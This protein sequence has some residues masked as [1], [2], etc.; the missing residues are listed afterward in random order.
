MSLTDYRK[1]RSF[2]HTPEPRGGKSRT[3]KL[4]FVVQKHDATQLHYD[5]RLEMGGVLKSWAVPKGPSTDP[6]VKRLAM[7]VEDHPVDYKDFEGIIPEGNYG[8]GTVIVWD[9]GT[10]EPAS[11]ARSKA[12][13]DKL[14]LK[15][16]KAGSL[17]VRLFGKKL[18]GEYALIHTRG[19]ADN[20]WLLIKHRDQYASPKDITEKDKSVVSGKTIEKMERSPDRIYGKFSGDRGQSFKK[21]T[22]ESSSQKRALKSH[23]RR[24]EQVSDNTEKASGPAVKKSLPGKRRVTPVKKK[25]GGSRP[26]P[27]E[28]PAKSRAGPIGGNGDCAGAPRASFPKALSP[29]LATLVDT[30][31]AGDDWLYEIKWD[32]YRAMA[33]CHKSQVDLV[34]RNNKSFNDKFYPIRQAFQ[35]LD[36]DAV[37]DGEV[38]V[39]KNDG[40][41]NFGALQ[42]WRSVADGELVYYVFDLLWL[43]GR[44]LMELPLRLRRECLRQLIPGSGIIRISESF[45]STMPE[46]LAA[47]REMGLEGIMAKRADSPYRPGDR[48]R[49]WIKIKLQKRHEVVIGGFTRNDD[50][51]KAFSSLLVGQYEKGKLRY[52]GKIGTGFNDQQQKEMMAQFKPLL[53]KKPP[54]DSIPEINQASR[55]RPD[56]PHAEAFWLK[57]KLVCEVSYTEMTGDGVMRHPSF[58]G[59]R[60]DK[61]AKD[62]HP[63]RPLPR[64]QGLHQKENP[65]RM[66]KNAG[67][68]QPVKRSARPRPR[69]KK[70]SAV[71]PLRSGWQK[72]ARTLLN[73]SEETQVKTVK[74]HELKFTHLSKVFW[75][76]EGYTKRDL[77]NY[78]YRVAPYLLPYLKD[79]P[80]SLNRFPNGIQGKSFYQKDV[81][82]SAPE[83]VK[84]FPYHTQ[85]GEDKNFLVV[86]DESSL[87]WMANLGAI[88]MNPWNSTIHKPDSPDWCIIDLDPTEK[89]SF[90][91]VIRTAQEARKLL[92]ELQVAAYPKTSGST[93]IHIYIPLAAKYSYDECQ[94]FAKMIATRVH[95]SLPEFTSIERMTDK[96]KGKI[97]IDYLQNRPKAT[98]ASP[99]SV[100]PK[101]G[102][103]VSMPLHWEEVKKGLRMT[104]FNIRNALERIAAEGD[105][106]KPVLGKGADIAKALDL[107]RPG[108][109]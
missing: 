43:N 3:G 19:K 34:S 1:K 76:K 46:F 73:P 89:N 13:A 9:Y 87:F 60:E 84:R 24:P 37:L 105:L 65:G 45:A 86:E 31:V 99:Y 77:L 93:G 25:S 103:T 15:E 12:E 5:F 16:L 101:P 79:R 90:D 38:T 17:K 30:T 10:Y 39:L 36:L 33:F 6:S 11:S 74:G 14:L 63:E 83:W 104:D 57:P 88:E 54:F 67:L 4:I 55:F 56:P 80:Q 69:A 81:T 85:E 49:D 78:Y 58:E 8:A 75:P 41:S 71:L 26:A 97:Y 94:L 106:F 109:V 18:Q 27:G 95:E 98:L 53:T 82:A 29:M 52:S 21:S 92:D 32:G 48:G 28:T 40:V 96:R 66:G 7:M 50:S 102:A 47:A 68:A 91:Q 107:L 22:R 108:A 62:V 61:A 20:A 64:G 35:E 59:M 42:N 2:Q 51:P 100:R 72:N 70:A 44:N 23:I